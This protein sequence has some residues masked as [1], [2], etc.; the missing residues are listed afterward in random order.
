MYHFPRTVVWS[1]LV[2][3][4]VVAGGR[5]AETKNSAVDSAAAFKKG[6]IR[7]EMI[8]AGSTEGKIAYINKAQGEKC[9]FIDTPEGR[10]IHYVCAARREVT[11]YNPQYNVIARGTMTAE[12][13][14]QATG[15]IEQCV[16]TVEEFLADLKKR[17]MVIMEMNRGREGGLA[18]T[19]ATYAAGPEAAIPMPAPESPATNKIWYSEKTGLIQKLESEDRMEVTYTYGVKIKDIY[20]LGFPRNAK[21]I[22]CRPTPEAV[23]LLARL[24]QRYEQDLG[25]T[26]VAVLCET[27]I[28][29]GKRTRLFLR[30]YAREA[31]KHLEITYNVSGREYTDS[32]MMAIQGWP[33]T[34]IKDIL[35]L[36]QKTLP[37]SYYADD[38]K[39]VRTGTYMKNEKTGKEYLSEHEGRRKDFPLLKYYRIAAEIWETRENLL[40]YGFSPRADVITDPKRPSA[41]GLRTRLGE[42]D[43][44]EVPLGQK[45]QEQIFWIDSTRNDIPLESLTTY[46]NPALPETKRSQFINDRYRYLK[47]ARLP[48]GTWYPTFWERVCNIA[49]GL[50][51]NILFGREYHLQVFQDMKLDPCWYG[52]RSK[53]LG[54]PS[55]SPPAD[56]KKNK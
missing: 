46:E 53:H 35:V 25:T 45:R 34:E 38:G 9:D 2:L 24:E 20:D 51:R 26:Y 10:M 37:S 29:E 42:F 32:P 28:R 41:V 43:K 48:N 12:E 7:L 13:S 27:D 15:E 52:S 39:M 22:E 21:V 40:L 31:D 3:L 6:W 16:L 55:I 44:K 14:A 30:L 18:F 50:K 4:I 8:P 49:T 23:A 54:I 17:G 47:F 36:G 56:S 5:A 19:E 33:R 11:E 1:L